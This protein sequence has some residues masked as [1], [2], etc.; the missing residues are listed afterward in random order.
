MQEGGGRRP[1][2]T[3]QSLPSQAIRSD[4]IL[5]AHVGTPPPA[6]KAPPPSACPLPFVLP[7]PAARPGVA[8]AT[9]HRT[10]DHSG[11]FPPLPVTTVSR[12]LLPRQHRAARTFDSSLLCRGGHGRWSSA[13]NNVSVARRSD[14]N[15]GI[16]ASPANPVEHGVDRPSPALSPRSILLRSWS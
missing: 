9:G 10:R 6:D 15:R 1:G 16:R 13:A 14:R 3:T 12:P 8:A 11:R 2:G 7:A 5:P 4:D